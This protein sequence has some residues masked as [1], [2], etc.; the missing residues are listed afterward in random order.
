M[1]NM[2]LNNILRKKGIDNNLIPINKTILYN[3]TPNE[4]YVYHYLLTAPN[5]FIPTYEAIGDILGVK[6]RT[7]IS[8]VLNRLKQ[9][10]LVNIQPSDNVYIWTIVHTNEELIYEPPV[11]KVQT[12]SSFQKLEQ[13]LATY[14]KMLDYEDPSKH[15]E[16]FEKIIDVKLRMNGGK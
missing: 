9:L 13:E 2:L 14:E 8:K 16:I 15:D 11:V 12:M 1:V 3:L 10:R 6:S 5:D 7:T 4:Y